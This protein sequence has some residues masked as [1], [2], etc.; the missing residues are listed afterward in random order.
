MTDLGLVS[1]FH[2]VYDLLMRG[3]FVL[4]LLLQ[5]RVFVSQLVQLR[6]QL[7]DL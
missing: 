3:A 7:L 2:L 6:V 4:I 1:E 5:E